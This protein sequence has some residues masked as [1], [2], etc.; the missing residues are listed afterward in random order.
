MGS[1]WLPHRWD[2]VYRVQGENGRPLD[3]MD[4]AGTRAAPRIR[5]ASEARARSHRRRLE[6]R[7]RRSAENHRPSPRSSFRLGK[8]ARGYW[9]LT[10]VGKRKAEAVSRDI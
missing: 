1:K 6:T 10:I 9:R 7:S 3:R 4:C 8:E 2:R 5:K